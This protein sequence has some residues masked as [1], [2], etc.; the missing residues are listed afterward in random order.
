MQK[1][2]HQ[3]T[4]NTKGE[5]KPDSQWAWSLNQNTTV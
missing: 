2:T 5:E 3:K 4:E 1:K